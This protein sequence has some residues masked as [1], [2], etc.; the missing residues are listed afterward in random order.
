M[1]DG[2]ERSP[3]AQQTSDTILK[4]T[5][6]LICPVFGS[7]VGNKEKCWKSNASLFLITAV[8][9]SWAG[10]RDGMRGNG[11]KV[12]LGRFRLGSRNNVLSKRA[13]LSCTGSGGS[14]SLGMHQSSGDVALS[15][16]GSG[17]GGLALDWGSERSLP[18][19]AAWFCSMSRLHI[20][21]QPSDPAEHVL[22]AEQP[23]ARKSSQL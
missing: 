3:T 23:R 7:L 5:P 2:G 22:H 17:H 8:F 21:A 9:L 14:P 6:T 4:L 19:M 12:H 1:A 13:V 10:G 16:V 15:D 11:L 20:P 18:T